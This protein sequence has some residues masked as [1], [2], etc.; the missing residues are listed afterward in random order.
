MPSLSFVGSGFEISEE[1]AISFFNFSA[2]IASNFG[3]NASS[4]AAF[5]F[6]SAVARTALASAIAS[7]NR[8]D[9]FSFPYLGEVI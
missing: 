2:N 7:F 9:I 3:W 5:A 1:S 8:F 4:N 6:A